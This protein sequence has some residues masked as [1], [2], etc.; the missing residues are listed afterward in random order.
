MAAKG[1]GTIASLLFFLLPNRDIIASVFEFA[2]SDADD[3][4]RGLGPELTIPSPNAAAAV[5]SLTRLGAAGASIGLDVILAMDALGIKGA[6][7]FFT[8]PGGASD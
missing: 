7:G 3:M 6:G 4:I 8:S 5:G 1:T 2:H